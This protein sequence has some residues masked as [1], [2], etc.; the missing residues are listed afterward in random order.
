[1]KVLTTH[2]AGYVVI[3]ERMNRAAARAYNDALFARGGMS[4]NG[5]ASLN[6]GD[7]DRAAEALMMAMILKVVRVEG[8]EDAPKEVDVEVTQAWL[9]DLDEQDF[10]EISNAVLKIKKESREQA[11]K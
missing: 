11:K 8:P 9:D 6:P 10:T 7:I 2:P 4:S 5:E 3:R 1:M